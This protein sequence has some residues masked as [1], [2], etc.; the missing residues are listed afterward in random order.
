MLTCGHPN[1]F[2]VSRKEAKE[3]VER[4]YN[5]RQEVQKWQ[6]ERKK[7]AIQQRRVHTLLG[8]AR[9]FPS[10]ANATQSQKGHIERAAINT[11]VQ[12][13]FFGNLFPYLPPSLCMYEHILKLMVATG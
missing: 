8:R 10:T 12:V 2:Q 5:G 7:E 1:S 6:E 3:T 13:K 11:P 4:W 9:T